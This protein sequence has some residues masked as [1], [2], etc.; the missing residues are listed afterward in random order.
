MYLILVSLTTFILDRKGCS[1][2]R[3]ICSHGFVS[4]DPWYHW[5]KHPVV[6]QSACVLFRNLKGRLLKVVQSVYIANLPALANKPVQPSFTLSYSV[7]ALQKSAIAKSGQ[8]VKPPR[9]RTIRSENRK[10]FMVAQKQRRQH[11]RA[12]TVAQP[13]AGSRKVIPDLQSITWLSEA[14]V[15]REGL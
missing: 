1:R 11:N 3:C 10:T 12:I 6:P 7:K 5:S 14:G 9:L 8:S 15:L 2:G 4:Q 13:N